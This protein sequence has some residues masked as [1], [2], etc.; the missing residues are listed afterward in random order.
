MIW[1]TI[2]SS[3]IV[4]TSTHPSSARLEIVGRATGTR[5]DETVTL[6]GFRPAGAYQVRVHGVQVTGEASTFTLTIDV[7]ST[8][9]ATVQAAAGLP[10]GAASPITVC[11]DA[12]AFAGFAGTARGV[13]LLGPAGAPRLLQLPVTW[14]AVPWAP[15]R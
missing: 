14:R 6:A 5:G 13:L 12:G 8:P 11:A 10:A 1:R 4:L 9:A 2:D 15:P 3:R 7:A